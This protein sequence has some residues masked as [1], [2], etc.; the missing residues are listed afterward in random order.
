MDVATTNKNRQTMSRIDWSKRADKAQAVMLGHSI[1]LHKDLR[2]GEFYVDHDRD[3]IVMAPETWAILASDA[4]ALDGVL[5]DMAAGSN[6]MRFITLETSP[7]FAQAVLAKSRN[8]G[9]DMVHAKDAITLLTERCSRLIVQA[10]GLD[11]ATSLQ[12]EMF[13]RELADLNSDFEAIAGQL[14]R[15]RAM[16]DLAASRVATAA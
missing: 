8:R 13:A 9:V 10:S 7:Q 1:F 15:L 5:K 4:T 3:V 12:L 11:G 6:G 16:L 14:G 2:V